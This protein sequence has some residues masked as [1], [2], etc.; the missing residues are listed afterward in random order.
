MQRKLGRQ[1]DDINIPRAQRRKPAPSLAQI[2]RAHKARDRAI[3]AAHDTGRYSY[4]QIGEHFGIHFTTVG[5]IV[6]AG[7]QGRRQGRHAAQDRD[8]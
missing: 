6:R 7:R 5:R 3:L 8:R 4:A 2:G 1:A